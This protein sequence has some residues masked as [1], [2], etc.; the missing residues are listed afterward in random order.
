LQPI[1]KTGLGGRIVAI[2][3]PT[4]ADDALFLRRIKWYVPADGRM[5]S[6]N[7]DAK[8]NNNGLSITLWECSDSYDAILIGHMAFGLACLTARDLRDEGFIIIRTP[9]NYNPWHCDAEGNPGKNT[10]KKLQNK[11]QWVKFPSGYPFPE[12][13]I[14]CP[15]Y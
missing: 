2:D 11:A 5:E 6:S 1:T 3:D 9:E 14:F 7:F 10:H 15:P 12:N 4:I 13:K 8:R